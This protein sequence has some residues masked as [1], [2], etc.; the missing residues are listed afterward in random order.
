MAT[1]FGLCHVTYQFDVLELNYLVVVGQ[2]NGEQEFVVLASV[3]GAG[4][5]VHVEFLGHDC[6][7]V[8]YG[9]ALLIYAAAGTALLA[10][11][12]EFR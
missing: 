2:G 7:L 6:G 5:D 10:D 3:Q 11:V 9:D 12:Y 1:K 8:I 4:V